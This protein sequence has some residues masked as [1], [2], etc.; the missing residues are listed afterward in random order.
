[1]LGL[2][3]RFD[4]T[5]LG[6]WAS[7][8]LVGCH[9]DLFDPFAAA[10]EVGEGDDEVPTSVGS[11]DEEGEGSGD[12]AEDTGE[13]PVFDVLGEDDSN[14]SSCEFAASLPSHLGCEF[15]GVDLDQAG[16]ADFDA[17]GFVLINPQKRAVEASVE[18]F[19][20]HGWVVSE[21]AT[22]E[23]EQAHVFLPSDM[24]KLDTGLYDSAVLRIRTTLPV[25][26]IQASP[27]EYNESQPGFSASATLL[28]PT[29]GWTDATRVV[30]WR[31]QA[32]LAERAFLGV[33][34]LEDFTPINL[35]LSFVVEPGPGGVALINPMVV[36]AGQLLRLSAHDDPKAGLAGTRVWSGQEQHSVV[37]SAHSC[38]A[39]P[40]DQGSTCGHMQEQLG[41]SLLGRHF[42]APRLLARVD[43]LGDDVPELIHERTMIQVVADEPDTQ[44]TLFHGVGQLLDSAVIDPDAP[45]TF[46][47]REHELAVVSDKPVTV[48]A[49]MTNAEFT[50][51]GSP[52]MV[53]LAPIEQWTTSHWVWVPQGFT[54][55]LVVLGDEASQIEI[56]ALAGVALALEPDQ[57]PGPPPPI[58]P[59]P[60]L[61]IDQ[62]S[63]AGEGIG[64]HQVTRWAVEPGIYRIDS[65]TP[66]SVVVVG[67]RVMDGF[68]YLG[69]WGPSLVDI[70]PPT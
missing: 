47:Q 68:A 60:G 41:N 28:Q 11:N 29:S 70:G 37:F 23:P 17:Y 12:A 1:M 7:L 35:D 31:T 24:E 57:T 8:A 45:Y 42:V 30:G 58:P 19:V 66:T 10:D 51:L 55:H 32:G 67:A 39:I 25:I 49:Y 36:G 65:Q 64:A 6:V 22:I 50:E 3:A 52:S 69:G 21:S 5:A 48:A 38:A 33:I 34:A 26:A 9:V 46:E 16:L 59:V 63:V 14:L 40:D 56:S 53:Q 61:P 15:F 54:T 43:V 13:P 4:R 44:I 27:A 2:T 20:D 18:R 62:A